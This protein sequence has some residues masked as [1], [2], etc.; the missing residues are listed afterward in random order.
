L[1]VNEAEVGPPPRALAVAA[2]A[3]ASLA[4]LADMP[5]VHR[6]GLALVEGGGR[7]LRFTASDRDSGP[8]SSWCDVDAYDDVPLNL[9]LRIASPV[10]GSLDDLRER[11]P[12][13][14]ERQLGTATASLAAVPI[15]EAGQT[16]G[17]YLLFFDQLQVFDDPQRR[18][19]AGVGREL[20]T[21]LRRAQT[22][23]PRVAETYDPLPPG[24]VDAV[25]EVAA[26]P[27]AVADARH[28]LQRTLHDWDIDEEAAHTA[29]LCLSEL[30]TNAVIHTHGGCLVRMVL[31]KGVLTATVRDHGGPETAPAGSLDDSLQVHGRGL[32]LV[33]ALADRWG[34]DLGSGGAS[35]W[36]VLKVA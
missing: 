23:R 13:Y 29:A 18:E 14:V 24:V 10:T 8:D 25:H 4:L 30:V 6:V 32:Q 2:W 21:A 22:G 28:F 35:V 7:R 5:D 12:E 27:A 33:E 20:G 9:A 26:D 19:L 31:E 1:A 34:Y 17:G 15:V 16:L 36:F 11:F 3:Q